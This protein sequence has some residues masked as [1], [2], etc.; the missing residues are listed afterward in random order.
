MSGAPA[1]RITAVVLAGGA[2]SRFGGDKLAAELDGIPVLERTL[3]ALVAADFAPLV[4]IGPYVPIPIAAE[5]VEGVRV[6]RDIEAFGGPLAG[7]AA[8]LPGLAASGVQVALV[9]GGDMPTPVP[10]VLQ[11]LLDA[12]AADD[13][14]A[15]VTLEAEPFA[16][17]PMAIRVGPALAAAQAVIEGS[18]R[19]SLRAML[20]AVP[21]AVIPAATWRAL[22]PAAATH[23]D[24]DTPADLA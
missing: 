11:L 23:R 7:L 15:A 6:V 16:A 14:P 17:L 12:L 18:G 20:G 24:I 1:A 21:S 8:V 5:R 22:D 10:A 3:R 4:A 2:S 19:R 13:A 9:T